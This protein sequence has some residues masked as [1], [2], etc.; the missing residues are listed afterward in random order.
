MSPYG[1]NTMNV[2]KEVVNRIR[3]KLT[4]EQDKP[5][6]ECQKNKWAM[7]KLVDEQELMKRE[8][9]TL[10]AMIKDLN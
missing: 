6:Y 1:V 10:G 7:K 5:K 2:K 8:I 4:K 9:A 3:D